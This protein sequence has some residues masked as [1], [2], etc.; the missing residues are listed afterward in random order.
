M[1]AVEGDT[2]RGGGTGHKDRGARIVGFDRERIDREI[3]R[4]AS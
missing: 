3:V 1:A 4:R 2:E